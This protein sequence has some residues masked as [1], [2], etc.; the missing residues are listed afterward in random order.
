MFINIDCIYN[1]SNIIF[2]FINGA[3]LRFTYL[4][5][6]HYNEA[7]KRFRQAHTFVAHST[8]FMGRL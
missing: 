8:N 5:D 6:L 1:V 3:V 2:F 7:L 4:S